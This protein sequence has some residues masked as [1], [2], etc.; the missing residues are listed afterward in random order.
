[1]PLVSKLFPGLLPRLIYLLRSWNV[2]SKSS[3]MEE[4]SPFVCCADVQ[5]VRRHQKQ[6]V[7]VHI[8][9]PNTFGIT[10]YYHI[11]TS[12]CERERESARAKETIEPELLRD[13][14]E[15][16]QCECKSNNQ[17]IKGERSRW[18]EVTSALTG[19]YLLAKI[20][21]NYRLHHVLHTITDDSVNQYFHVPWN[22]LL[23]WGVRSFQ[24]WT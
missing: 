2:L 23:I 10:R 16:W 5:K 18:R 6:E 19:V 1:M 22:E 3:F 9:Y 14:S 24:I 17:E 12:L 15:N 20:I 7:C 21:L 4:S 11:F 13:I 8:L